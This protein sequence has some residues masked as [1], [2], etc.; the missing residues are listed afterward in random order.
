MI[1]QGRCK[2][3]ARHESLGG[4]NNHQ[5]ICCTVC[6]NLRQQKLLSS[7]KGNKLCS[8]GNKSKRT[9]CA[10]RKVQRSFRVMSTSE[11]VGSRPQMPWLPGCVSLGKGLRAYF[12]AE[13]KAKLKVEFGITTVHLKSG[14]KFFVAATYR[15][16]NGKL[17][18]RAVHK[19]LKPA[20]EGHVYKF[21]NGNPLDLRL[22]NLLV[23][24]PER[25]ERRTYKPRVKRQRPEN[26]IT[27]E[28]AREWLITPQ[29]NSKG[30]EVSVW[31]RMR[32]K[33]GAILR[34]DGLAEVIHSDCVIEVLT[35]VDG[36][37]F[38][39]T[40]Y[41]TFLNWCLTICDGQATKRQMGVLCGYVGD[42]EEDP[43]AIKLKAVL[44][45]TKKSFGSSKLSTEGR[46]YGAKSKRAEGSDAQFDAKMPTRLM[47]RESKRFGTKLNKRTEFSSFAVK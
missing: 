33:I 11:V 29:P 28:Q 26:P 2:P 46:S 14:N 15:D 5:A 30:R 25:K 1:G 42:I 36:G 44:K 17:V 9:L 7:G 38:C 41:K 32:E 47:R 39:G 6:G 21:A 3:L 34:Q 19:L 13:G 4:P 24:A 22:S 45:E 40:N 43:A 31:E 27:P 35:Q 16:A 10:K 18:S 8:G 20:E 23:A 12:C 37:K